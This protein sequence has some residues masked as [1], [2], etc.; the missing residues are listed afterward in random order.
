MDAMHH[1]RGYDELSCGMEAA[2]I[3]AHTREGE[4]ME[5]PR[6]DLSPLLQN[7]KEAIAQI[8]LADM[9]LM[10]V[11]DALYDIGAR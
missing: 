1:E 9:A 4:M 5:T 8:R 6:P 3:Q 11:L 2:S 7:V 10:G